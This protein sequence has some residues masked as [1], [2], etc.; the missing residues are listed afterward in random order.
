MRPLPRRKEK[1]RTDSCELQTCDEDEKMAPISS[2]VAFIVF[3]R[4]N[5]SDKIVSTIR[6]FKIY[7]VIMS[8]NEN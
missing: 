3:F 1:G 8:L 4:G 2:I 6:H 7:I 5:F